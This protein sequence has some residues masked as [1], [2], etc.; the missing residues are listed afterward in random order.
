M[1]HAVICRGWWPGPVALF[2]VAWCNSRPVALFLLPGTLRCTGRPAVLE[3][4]GTCGFMYHVVLCQ[5]WWPVARTGPWLFFFCLAHWDA[6]AG[7]R[8]C[9]RSVP[10]GSCLM[11]S[12]GWWP[13]QIQARCSFSSAWHIGMHRL[14]G[15]AVD[16]APV[17]SCLMQSCGWRPGAHPG[18]LLFFFCLEHCDAQAGRRCCW[19][20]RLRDCGNRFCVCVRYCEPG[21][22]C[23]WSVSVSGQRLA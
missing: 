3:M 13:A 14:A 8:C 15:G 4:F 23:L 2:L 9:W 12:C 18:P 20:R 7:R 6:Q 1:S 21:A 19:R 11:Q 17:G 5:G 10:V 22:V 16:S